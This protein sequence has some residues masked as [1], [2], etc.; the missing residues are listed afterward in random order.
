MKH[1]SFSLRGL[2]PEVVVML[3]GIV[4]AL[5]IGK[6][7]PAIPVLQAELGVTLVQ[8][9]FLLSLVQLAGM[10]GGALIGVLADSAG[11]RRS[12]LTGLGI[13]TASSVMG[14]LASSATELLLLRGLEGVG[15]LLVTLSGPGLI[16]QLVSVEKLSL[17][18]G[19]WGCYMG[20]G[21]GTGLLIGPWL[22]QQLGWQG[23]WWLIAAI[24]LVML[25][26]VLMAVPA[27]RRDHDPRAGSPLSGL[28]VLAGRLKLTLSSPGPWLVALI[29]PMYSG[30]WLSVIG[31]LPSIY[32]QAGLEGA[33]VGVLTAIAAVANVV[34]NVASGRLLQAGVGARQL[35]YLGFA[36]MTLTTWTAFS[37]MTSDM[38]WLRYGAV[39]VFSSVSGV[40]PGVLFSLAVR[41]APD[42]SVVSTSVGWMLQLSALGQFIAPP[43]IGALAVWA[44]GWQLTW[45]A[46][47]GLSLLGVLLVTRVARLL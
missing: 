33:V 27:D 20:F 43:I 24:T 44:G 11:L 40:I 42:S 37:S 29:F 25:A 9:G 38:P 16:R 41:L 26:W 23:W 28:R 47:G 30:Q 35:L 4:A 19:W 3:A 2:A 8:A 12:V 46:T 13:L 15:F 22:M 5:H 6:L 45:L 7:P 21:T 34:G 36:V 18:L 32:T 1:L 10:I 14:G 39:L 17:R 31:F